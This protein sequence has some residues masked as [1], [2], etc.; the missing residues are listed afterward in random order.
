VSASALSFH[1]AAMRTAQ[2]AA[3]SEEEVKFFL[4][5]K[6]LPNHFASK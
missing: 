3:L 1:G 4:R 2:I 6:Y 5:N